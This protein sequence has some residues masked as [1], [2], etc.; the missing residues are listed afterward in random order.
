VQETRI[1]YVLLTLEKPANIGY[2]NGMARR[3]FV[4]AFLSLQTLIAAET[5]QTVLVPVDVYVG[6][7]AFIRHTFSTRAGLLGADAAIDIPVSAAVFSSLEPDYTVT[8]VSRS[9]SGTDCLL[10]VWF[11]PWKIGDFDIPPF[12]LAELLG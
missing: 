12:D 9:A 5:R 7:T 1:S 3:L 4:L 2:S 11:T 10:T 6:D 8:K